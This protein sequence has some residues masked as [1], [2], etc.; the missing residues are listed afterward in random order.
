MRDAVRCRVGASFLPQDVSRLE[1]ELQYGEAQTEHEEVVHALAFSE[2]RACE[3]DVS[4]HGGVCVRAGALGRG[5]AYQLD[6]QRLGGVSGRQGSQV[7]LVGT[8]R[9]A[10]SQTRWS[11]T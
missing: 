1:V 4:R 5:C 2:G 11:R 6:V 10:R 9:I 3:H 8:C 7:E